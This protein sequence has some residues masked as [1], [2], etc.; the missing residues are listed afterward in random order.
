MGR[1]EPRAPNGPRE[2]KGETE[3]EF[4]MINLISHGKAR[5]L[6]D[7]SDECVGKARILDDKSDEF[8]GKARSE[9][10]LGKT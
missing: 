8:V 1:H 6:D 5:I 3:T 4:W 10:P 9:N 2:T 7:K